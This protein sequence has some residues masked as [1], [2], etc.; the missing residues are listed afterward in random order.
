M[1]ANEVSERDPEQPLAPM[2]SAAKPAPS[3][4]KKLRSI[5]SI[6]RHRTLALG[7]L[8]FILAAAVWEFAAHVL[9]HNALYLPSLE[10]IWNRFTQLVANGELGGDLAASGKEFIY[11]FLLA[12]VVGVLLGSL[13]AMSTT[14]RLMV[15]PILNAAYATPL[16]ALAP[17][18]ILWFGIGTGGKVA[19]VFAVAVFPIVIN[20]TVGM[21]SVDPRFL[22]VGRSF[23]ASRT[24]VFRRILFPYSLSFIVSG[25]R[26]GLGRGLIGVVIGELFASQEGI[27]YLIV[28]SGQI[29]DT[30]AA[31]VAILILAFIGVVGVGILHAIENHLAPW[32]ARSIRVD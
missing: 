5:V 13:L 11:G 10:S 2:T 25:I 30:A 28:H 17:L 6:K 18:L 4:M 12:I 1:S 21:R 9:I 14:I 32:K 7:L 27:G 8:G 15:D 24:Q 29:F 31:F 16:V 26:L 20:T 23:G 22:A 19:V 3:T